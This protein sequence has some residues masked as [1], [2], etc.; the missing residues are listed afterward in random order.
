MSHVAHLKIKLIYL[1]VYKCYPADGIRVLGYGYFDMD[2]TVTRIRL[3]LPI[4]DA[5]FDT[6][7]PLSSHA[8]RF[9]IKLIS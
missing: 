1:I 4:M 5:Q 8:N 9:G 3:H 7:L 2:E 6:W